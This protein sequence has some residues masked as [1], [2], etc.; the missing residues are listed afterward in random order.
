MNPVYCVYEYF[1]YEISMKNKHLGTVMVTIYF[2][3]CQ[4]LTEKIQLY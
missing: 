4:D 2:L 3:T 1:V